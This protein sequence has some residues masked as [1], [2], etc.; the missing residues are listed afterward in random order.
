M[1]LPLGVVENVLVNVKG[2]IVPTDFI[3]LD[4]EED[5]EVPLLLGRPF[6]ATDGAVIDVKNSLLSLNIEGKKMN[7]NLKNLGQYTNET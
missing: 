2:S 4:M 7:S 5:K 3:V 6:L 1:K